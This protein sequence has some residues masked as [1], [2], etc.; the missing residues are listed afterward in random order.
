MKWLLLFVIAISPQKEKTSVKIVLFGDLM[1]AGMDTLKAVRNDPLFPFRG[2]LSLIREA[3]IAIANLE[4][5]LG[6]YGI[7]VEDKEYTFLTNPKLASYAKAAGFDGFVLANNHIMDYG[8]AALR[9]TI[10]TLDSLGIKHAGAGMNVGEARKPMI[11]KCKGV[12]IGVLA[13]SN[14]FPKSYWA[15]SK[16]AGTA[17]GH[18]GFIRSDVKRLRDSVDFVIVYFHW[19]AERRI[20]PKGYQRTLAHIAIDAGADLVVGSHPHI[21]QGIEVYRGRLIFYSLGN[22][23]FR[24]TTDSASGAALLVKL[25]PQDSVVYEIVPLKVRYRDVRYSPKVTHEKGFIERIRERSSYKFDV[26]EQGF[27]RVVLPH[28]RKRLTTKR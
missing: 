15:T 26:N 9:Q 11:F 16:R 25:F 19:G 10:E 18:V 3:D 27:G 28:R 12:K 22:Y 6:T 14:T 2:T 7:R 13:Y 5:P 24:S 20:Q 23:A 4:A 1:M 21:V 17:F 8:T